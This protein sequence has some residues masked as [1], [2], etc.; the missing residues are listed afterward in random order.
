[1]SCNSDSRNKSARMGSQGPLGKAGNQPQSQELARSLRQRWSIQL[2]DTTAATNH[3]NGDSAG[4]YGNLEFP[5]FSGQTVAS[6]FSR[7]N[8][9]EVRT[10]N[11][12]ESSLSLRIHQGTSRWVQRTDDV[13]RPRGGDVPVAVEI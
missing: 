11:P 7:R 9:A 12:W 6:R 13:S 3:W 1:M 8:D 4:F 2:W 10:P 5:G